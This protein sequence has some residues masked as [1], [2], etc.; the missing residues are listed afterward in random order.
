MQLKLFD[1]R[2]TRWIALPTRSDEAMALAAIN[3]GKAVHVYWASA[4]VTQCID[5][6]EH[7]RPLIGYFVLT[8]NSGPGYSMN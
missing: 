4:D 1:G 8:T 7:N 2:I 6:W 3:S 5:G